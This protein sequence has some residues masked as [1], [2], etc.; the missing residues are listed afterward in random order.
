M[1]LPSLLKRINPESDCRTD[2]EISGIFANSKEV[3]AGSLFV[4]VKGAKADGSE[5]IAEAVANGAVCVAAEDICLAVKY[6]EV[7]FV[8]VKDSRY[9]LAVLA[10]EFFN[11]PSEQIKAVGITGTNGKTTITYLI[12][13]ILE[14]AGL[15]SGV[16]GTINYSFKDKVLA[17][18]NTTPGPL[19]LQYL[20]REMASCGCD[21]CLMEVS[22]HSLE[23][24]RTAAIDFKAAIF[25]NLTQD[26]LDYHLNMENYFLAKAKLFSSLS[27]TAWAIVNID[28]P[29][30][31]RL[32]DLTRGKFIGYGIGSR[33][34]LPACQTAV[35]ARGLKLGIDGSE[36]DLE[37][38]GHKTRIKTNLIGRHNIYNILA[39]AA[40]AFSQNIKPEDIQAALTKFSGVK[41]RLERVKDVQ[42]R[43]VFVDYAHTP[44]ALENVLAALKEFSSNRL[45]V[46]FGCG[47]E[48]DRLKRPLMGRTAEKYADR[49]IITS[50]NPRG[51][52]PGTIAGEITCGIKNKEY[53]VILDRKEAIA[54]AL[55]NSLFGETILIAGKGHEDYQIFKDRKIYFDDVQAVRECVDCRGRL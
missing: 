29:Y 43:F 24:K 27:Q 10:D 31:S 42:D 25:T 2:L 44:D 18:V 50:D 49:I 3:K 51:E 15:S 37:Y 39:S 33:A 34:G 40:F 21:Y 1:R 53:K 48:R 4:A 46:V 14:Q 52:E 55:G 41:G 30:A 54:Y 35:R 47:G 26:H 12:R 20:L 6:P 45:T 8:R 9:A 38:E 23:Q 5:F 36:F 19:E 28:S 32:K 17:A 13:A 7:E 11:H 22:S 16:I